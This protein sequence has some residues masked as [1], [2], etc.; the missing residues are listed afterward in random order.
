MVAASSVNL[1]C[2]L[3]ELAITSSTVLPSSKCCSRLPSSILVFNDCGVLP[4]HFLSSLLLL[5]VVV[6]VFI[7]KYNIVS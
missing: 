7:T 4:F 6:A 2:G 3:I 5:P 1:H